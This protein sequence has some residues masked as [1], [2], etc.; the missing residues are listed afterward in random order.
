MFLLRWKLLGH[1][2]RGPGNNGNFMNRVSTRQ[3][4]ATNVW[5]PSWYAVTR[6][7]SS[8]HQTAALYT[9]H[10]FIFRAFKISHSHL[11][12]TLPLQRGRLHSPSWP[13]QPR[14][15]RSTTGQYG[16]IN[17]N[18]HRYVFGVDS[19]NT[20]APTHVWTRD[21]HLTVKSRDATE[22]DRGHRTIRSAIRM[23]P[24]FDSKPSI[25]TKS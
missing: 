8:D 16:K 23:T 17:I 19:E 7:S 15:P 13:D 14:K 18:S 2:T 1:P 24:S 9:H 5:P 4:L 25:S 22:Q 21:H 12:L 3:K 10:N 6:F 20:K 11:R